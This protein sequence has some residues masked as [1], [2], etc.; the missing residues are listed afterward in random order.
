MQLCSPCP[1]KTLP[2]RQVLQPSEDPPE[3]TGP[4][5]TQTCGFKTHGLLK[6]QVQIADQEVE[7][8]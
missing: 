1:Q 2:G 6:L 3:G 7:S 5:F 8:V 4:A